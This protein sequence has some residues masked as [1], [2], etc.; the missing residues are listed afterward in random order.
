MPAALHYAGIGRRH[1]RGPLSDTVYGMRLSD[2]TGIVQGKGSPRLIGAWMTW[3][4]QRVLPR[5]ADMELKDVAEFLP[6]ISL[7][8]VVNADLVRMRVAGTALRQIYGADITG[9]NIKDITAPGDWP[10]RSRRYRSV[11][12]QPCGTF[13]HRRD[14]LPD[15]RIVSYEGIALPV[16]A[17]AT[18]QVRQMIN[19][20]SPLQEQ[21]TLE[22]QRGD[23]VLPM[24]TS[25]HFVDIGAGVPDG[26]A[27]MD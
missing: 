14:T 27:A 13:Y 16:D 4:G 22:T 8:E 17:D 5:K 18:G 10:E 15:G 1:I 24:P 7:M 21:Y 9:R 2:L 23:R 26:P 11:V 3:R 20:Y 19:I 12:T 25:F 6:W